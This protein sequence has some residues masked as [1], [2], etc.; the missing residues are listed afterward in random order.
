[1]SQPRTTTLAA[2][3]WPHENTV[4]RGIVFAVVGSL[5]LTLAAKVKIP[6]EPVPVTL[7]VFVLLALALTMGARL[8]AAT[9]LLYLAQGATGLPVF[10]GT[11]EKGLGLVYMLGGTGGYLIG[12]LIAATAVGWLADRGF[13]HRVVLSFI[14]V[15]V[16]LIAI[17]VPGLLW[18]ASLY[19]WDKPILEWG[20]YPFI[21]PDL[22]KAALAACLVP[23]TWRLLSG[24][25]KRDWG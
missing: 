10:T 6:I 4:L 13:S 21:G 1:M 17:Y 18:L 19:G 14:A 24:G 8:A 16:G 7:Q 5:L 12:F 20:F 9:V 22:L 23:A 3:L 25:R 2:T 15:I 11:P